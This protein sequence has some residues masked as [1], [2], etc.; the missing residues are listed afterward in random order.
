[1]IAVWVSGRRKGI[2]T[3]SKVTPARFNISQARSDQEE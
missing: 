3:S 1:M 2:I